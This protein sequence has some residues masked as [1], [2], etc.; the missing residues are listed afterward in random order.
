MCITSSPQSPN[1]GKDHSRKDLRLSLTQS[2]A[3]AVAMRRLPALMYED[4]LHQCIRNWMATAVT[5]AIQSSRVPIM[6]SGAV[7]D[8]SGLGMNGVYAYDLNVDSWLR[9]EIDGTV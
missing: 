3:R 2:I 8:P 7:E 4:H 1:K 9:H 6:V 5:T